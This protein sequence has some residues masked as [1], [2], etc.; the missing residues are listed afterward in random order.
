MTDDAQ[1]PDAQGPD[2]HGLQPE[3]GRPGNAQHGNAQHGN[4]QHGNA[5][6]GNERP[7]QTPAT[8]PIMVDPAAEARVG[9]AFAAFR[10]VHRTAVSTPAVESVFIAARQQQ[11]RRH[12][13]AG[14]AAAAALA[15]AVGTGALLNLG[16]A[17]NGTTAGTRSA[18]PTPSA[19]PS[20]SEA[21]PSP[22][23]S[24]KSGG[25][26]AT[27]KNPRRIDLRN[28]TV[29]V[30]VMATRDTCPGGELRF[31]DGDATDSA[32]CVWRIAALGVRYANLDGVAGEEMVTT[33]QAGEPNSEFTG[34]VVGLKAPV[35]GVVKPMGYVVTGK[36]S[37]QYIDSLTAAS[38]GLITVGISD[39]SDSP[40]DPRHQTRSYRWTGAGFTQVDG[41]T[42]F[43]EPGGDPTE[44]EPSDS[45]SP[46]AGE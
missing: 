39:S 25:S 24:K 36:N 10:D 35:G 20:P 22:S 30:P 42:E 16:D 19:S 37:A 13:V 45:P 5:Q 43:P 40:E 44:P 21:S 2:A 33:L 7:E 14:L 3:N 31:S 4:A 18:E 26:T 29:Q 32:G 15:L 9:A 17:P 23:P 27:S 34:G 46:A 38:D 41:P 8:E 11:R 6:H 1:R 12:Y 28:A